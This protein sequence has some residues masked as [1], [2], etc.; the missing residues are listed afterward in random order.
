NGN[1]EIWLMENMA[2]SVGR[3]FINKV[4]S[5]NGN[6]Y[7]KAESLGG[8]HIVQILSRTAPVKKAKVA[9]YVLAVNPSTETHT[10]LYNQLSSYSASNNNAEKFNTGAKEAGYTVNS[11]EC[12]AEDYSLPG[13]N[14]AR[15][16]I[17]W[18]FNAD[19]GE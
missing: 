12:S 17:R 14:D 8:E 6:G 18:A 15:Q 16:A 13:I 4:F 10:A 2:S 7:F 11:Y 1:D 3:P 19:K 9:A 5:E